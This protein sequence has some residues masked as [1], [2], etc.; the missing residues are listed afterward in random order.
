MT[1]TQDYG[2]EVRIC[3]LPHGSV[4]SVSEG[5]DSRF[6][7]S[8]ARYMQASERPIHVLDRIALGL[9]AFSVGLKGSMTRMMSSYSP[10]SDRECQFMEGL[11]P[12]DVAEHLLEGL[13]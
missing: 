2:D 4:L 11:S 6:M 5:D 8:I 3:R 9:G 1:V 13:R 7:P 10:K 12:I